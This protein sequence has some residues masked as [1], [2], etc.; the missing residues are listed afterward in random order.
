M[1]KV[2]CI[3]LLVLSL[4]SAACAESM[5]ADYEALLT[6]SW[7]TMVSEWNL[8]T[9]PG[10]FS[11][12]SEGVLLTY[13]PVGKLYL[14]FYQIN[15]DGGFDRSSQVR[16][17]EVR[18]DVNGTSITLNDDYNVIVYERIE[19]GSLVGGNWYADYFIEKYKPEPYNPGHKNL[20]GVRLS[21]NH[22]GTACLTLITSNPRYEGY[23][24]EETTAFWTLEDGVLTLTSEAEG[25]ETMQGSFDGA[26]I[27]FS[28][29]FPDLI[30]QRN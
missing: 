24:E 27:D 18:F 13:T 9:L 19:T 8:N 2:F 25:F 15:E 4:I 10:A 3:A 21:F 1:K 5:T 14:N 20:I 22:D 16:A 23:Y 30:L 26:A 6:G 29:S 12:P 28:A 17:Y 7:S 11:Y